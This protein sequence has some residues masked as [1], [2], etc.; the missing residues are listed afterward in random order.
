MLKSDACDATPGIAEFLRVMLPPTPSAVPPAG[1]RA[2]GG[3]GGFGGLPLLASAGLSGGC[4]LEVMP[5]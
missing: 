5:P 2:H 1:S 4:L 3:V